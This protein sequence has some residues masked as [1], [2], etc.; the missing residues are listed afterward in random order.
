MSRE[1]DFLIVLTGVHFRLDVDKGVLPGIRSPAQ[2]AHRHCVCVNEPRS[3]G[4]RR[5]SVSKMTPSRHF[6]ALLLRSPVH[7]S[8][9]D[10]TMPMDKFRSVRVIEQIDGDRNAFTKA[11]Q[12]SGHV[13]VVSDGA[14]R[15]AFGNIRQHGANMQCDV[16][17]ASQGRLFRVTR[18]GSRGTVATA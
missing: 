1:E 10:L 12:R 6:E 17:R 3:C 7:R 14:D 16:R 2:I 8:R 18:T 13:P 4:L 15:V 5:H 9:N 11:D